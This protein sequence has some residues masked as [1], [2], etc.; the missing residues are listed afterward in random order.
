M[1]QVLYVGELNDLDGCLLPGTLDAVSALDE[2]TVI[3]S[4]LL[5]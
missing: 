1:L 3:V 4:L 2:D 5:V